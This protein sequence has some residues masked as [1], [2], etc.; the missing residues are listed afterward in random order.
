MLSNIKL[1]SNISV[2]ASVAVALP[3]VYTGVHMVCGAAQS[4]FYRIFGV[5]KPQTEVRGYVAPGYEH[6]L[7]LIHYNIMYYHL[8]HRLVKCFAVS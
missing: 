3:V 4:P 5:N 6:V 8:F 2:A 7:L 1:D